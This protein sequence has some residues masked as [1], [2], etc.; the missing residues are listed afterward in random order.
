MSDV[1]I[2]P[3]YAAAPETLVRAGVPVGA[4]HAFTMD[5]RDSAIYPGIRRLENEI[6]KRRDAFGNRIAAAEHEQSEA[7]P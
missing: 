6:T 5:S 7:A 2:G 3:D 4:V 1:V